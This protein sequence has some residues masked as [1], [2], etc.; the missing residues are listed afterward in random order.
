M[1]RTGIE[2]FGFYLSVGAYLRRHDNLRSRRWRRIYRTHF[3]Q[4]PI[5]SVVKARS[6]QRAAQTHRAKITLSVF[7]I[8]HSSA[9]CSK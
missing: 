4:H 3:L 9:P 7:F 2:S 5:N 6:E 1:G 8:R